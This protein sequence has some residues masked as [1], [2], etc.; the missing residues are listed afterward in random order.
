MPPPAMPF[1]DTALACPFSM[2]SPET[3]TVPSL[4]MN[5]VPAAS[6]FTLVVEAPAPAM[7]SESRDEALMVSFSV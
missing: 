4:M 2:V 5:T 1:A 6:P 3:V 7:V